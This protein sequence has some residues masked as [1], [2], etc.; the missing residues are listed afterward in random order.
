M[1]QEYEVIWLDSCQVGIPDGQGD[2]EDC[3]EPA[4]AIVVFENEEALYVCQKHLEQIETEL[5]ESEE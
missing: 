4:V 2:V 1:K 5:E 3:K